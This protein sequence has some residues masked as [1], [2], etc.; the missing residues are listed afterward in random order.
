VIIERVL[1]Q[2]PQ[3]I[4]RQRFGFEEASQERRVAAPIGEMRE[5]APRFSFFQRVAT[6]HDGSSEI[7]FSVFSFQP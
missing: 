1:R 2:S 6:L 7:Q 4:N 3:L 5:L